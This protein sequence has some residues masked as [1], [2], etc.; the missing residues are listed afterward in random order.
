MCRGDLNQAGRVKLS[1]E[2]RGSRFRVDSHDVLASDVM[3]GAV[4][5]V[6]LVRVCRILTAHWLGRM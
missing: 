4:E 3:R 2:E 1:F 6:P 5:I